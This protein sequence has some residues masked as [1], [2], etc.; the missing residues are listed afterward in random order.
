MKLNFLE[1]EFII[2]KINMSSKSQL[3][4]PRIPK[5]LYENR[6]CNQEHFSK[7]V[8]GGIDKSFKRMNQ[9]LK[10]K[11]PSFKVTEFPSMENHHDLLKIATI[12]S[13]IFAFVDSVDTYELYEI[14]C[15]SVEIY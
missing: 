6:Y 8:C 12:R 2:L 7:L 4:S 14:F 5:V 11:V 13:D 15:T 10:I 3:F 1:K 9:V